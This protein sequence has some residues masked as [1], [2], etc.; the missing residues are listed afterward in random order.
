M[1]DLKATVSKTTNGFH[2]EG[3]EKIEYDFNFLDGVFDSKN[4]QLARLYE[5]WHRCL[6]IMDKNIYDLYG[7]QMQHY[8]NHHGLDLRIHQT[9]IGEKAKSL[10]TFTSI[11]NSMTEFGIVWKEPVLVVGGGL[12]TDL[13]YIS[14]ACAA[15]RRNTNYIRI[16]TTVIVLIDASVSI[17]VAVNYGNYKNR[18]AQ[19]RNGFAEPIKISSC[20]HMRT[21]DL[22]DEYC[23]RLITTKF[24]QSH[25][26]NGEV[27]KAADEINR[28]GIYEMLKLESPRLVSTVSLRTGTYGHHCTR[29]LATTVPFRHATLA[30]DRGL[31]SDTEHRRLLNLL[32]RA[33]LS[34][35]NDVFD[36]E[37]LTKAMK[38]ILKTRVGL[39]RAAVLSLL[40]DYKFW[41]DVSNEEMLTALRHHKEL[42]KEYP[43]TGYTINIQPADP[44]IHAQDMATDNDAHE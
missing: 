23:E 2:V 37:M 17:K 39:L 43:D 36:A 24:G 3:Y 5:R 6:A 22:L 12:A 20:A 19:F 40:G 16:P 18:L 32:S 41:N 42:M 31:L 44:Q 33:G 4:P 34:M 10:E 26:D 7:L 14:F 27:K 38:A 30:N 28:N 11:V 9:M 1:S 15:Y 21:F 29:S 13:K 8:S 35:E 25:D